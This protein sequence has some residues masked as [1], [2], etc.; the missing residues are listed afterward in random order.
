MPKQTDVTLQQGLKAAF[1]GDQKLTV[2]DRHRAVYYCKI[3]SHNPEVH[4]DDCFNKYHY[5][6]YINF[7]V[8]WVLNNIL[9]TDTT[10]NH[11]IVL[12]TLVLFVLIMYFNQI[13]L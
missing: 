7:S 11:P 4:P 8:F 13:T 6:E 3:C 1:S 12:R 5:H 10:C 2:A 9:L